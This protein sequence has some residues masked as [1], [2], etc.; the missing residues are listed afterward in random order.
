[1]I[2][3][4]VRKI[5]V[6]SRIKG[7]SAEEIKKVTGVSI[8]AINSII[9]NYRERGTL[10]GNYPGR[11]LIITKKQIRAVERKDR[12]VKKQRKK[13]QKK[14]RTMKKRKIIFLDECGINTNM[15]RYYG[16]SKGKKRVYDYVPAK[17]QSVQL[18]CHQ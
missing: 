17:K 13:W 3:V 18:C 12:K 14:Q 11:Q 8:S 7:I 6:E 2:P 1:M 10:E 4:E 9:R 15:T 16:R 5:I